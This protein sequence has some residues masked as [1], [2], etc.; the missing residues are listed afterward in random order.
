MAEKGRA[1]GLCACH[2]HLQVICPISD[3]M[4]WLL[5]SGLVGKV[6]SHVLVIVQDKAWGSWVLSNEESKHSIRTLS[7][8]VWKTGTIQEIQVHMPSSP[9]KSIFGSL[10]PQE[11]RESPSASIMERIVRLP[12]TPGRFSSW[13]NTLP[14]CFFFFNLKKNYKSNRT[15][16]ENSYKY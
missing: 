10:C 9:L 15:F 8:R 3:S 2:W 5:A 16:L 6:F 7:T 14:F 1:A 13:L 4:T 12:A 11:E